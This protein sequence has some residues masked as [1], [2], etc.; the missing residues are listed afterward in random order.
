M[1]MVPPLHDV[2]LTTV[3]LPYTTPDNIEEPGDLSFALTC[4]LSCFPFNAPTTT[5]EA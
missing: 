2:I 5:S 4:N 1:K 3:Q